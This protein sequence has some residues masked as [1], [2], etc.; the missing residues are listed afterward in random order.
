[1]L[2]GIGTFTV[3]EDFE[4]REYTEQVCSQEG[5]LLWVGTLSWSVPLTPALSSTARGRLQAP[6]PEAAQELQGADGVR[7]P[8]SA[9]RIDLRGKGLQRVPDQVWA[10]ASSHAEAGPG[11]QCALCIAPRRACSMHSIAG[12]TKVFISH[13][14]LVNASF[15]LSRVL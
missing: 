11:R 2:N 14:A 5:L 13:I 6:E 4:G 7:I 10:S 8:E 3:S 9:A 12:V 15:M 1:M